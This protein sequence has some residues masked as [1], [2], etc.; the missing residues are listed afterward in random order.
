M[1]QAGMVY[2]LQGSGDLRDVTEASC[3][4]SGCCIRAFRSPRGRYSMTRYS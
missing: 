4:V 3:S 2:D 1:Q